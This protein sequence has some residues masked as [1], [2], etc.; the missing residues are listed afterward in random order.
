MKTKTLF[1]VV[2]LLAFLTVLTAFPV[3]AEDEPQGKYELTATF[4]TNGKLITHRWYD[5]LDERSFR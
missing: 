3:S 1:P 5:P 4:I 2:L